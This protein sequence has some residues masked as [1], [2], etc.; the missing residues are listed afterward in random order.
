MTQ[1]IVHM[2]RWVSWV[3]LLVDTM[4]RVEV[5]GKQIETYLFEYKTSE[6]LVSVYDHEIIHINFNWFKF[7]QNYV[8]KS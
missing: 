4:K 7:T 8:K 3:L 2:C 1:S 6:Y 5:G